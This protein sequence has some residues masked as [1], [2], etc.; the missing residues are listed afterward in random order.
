MKPKWFLLVLAAI[1]IVFAGCQ[2]STTN[3]TTTTAAATTTTSTA[4]G[5]STTAAGATT[6][7]T[8]TEDSTT[9]TAGA[10]T[11][12]AAATTTTTS[13]G[14]STTT[15][16]VLVSD[17]LVAYYAFDESSGTTASDSSGNDLDGTVY[18]A[19]SVTGKVGNAL[20]F[21]GTND[22]VGIPASGEAAPAEIANL[23]TGSIAVWFKYEGTPP[24]LLPI[25]YMGAS[26]EV[27]NNNE[28]CII[29]LGHA[30]ISDQSQNLFYTVTMA[31]SAEPVF[32][33]DSRV[34]ITP[35]VWNHFVVTVG[36]YE[37][38]GYLNG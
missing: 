25:L 4:L 27:I 29:E 30:G 32:C 31:G 22:Y 2:A 5:T 15:T 6:T 38:T 28:G 23:D 21:D 24:M 10:T 14:D 34:D 13:S 36:S 7:T 18:G 33:Y 11:T 35:E 9:T 17:G 12:T 26:P 37:N 16:T 19:T 20:E 3:T 8:V 1:V